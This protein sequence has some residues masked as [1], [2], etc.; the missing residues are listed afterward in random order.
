MDD[1]VLIA[2][3][4]IVREATFCF[5]ELFNN[6]GLRL[7]L[8]KCVLLSNSPI[9]TIVDGTEIQAKLYST[10]AIRHLGPVLANND[11]V[12]KEWFDK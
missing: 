1:V 4:T 6:I 11:E 8:L 2:D 3:L 12:T 10:D 7:N 9:S 5:K